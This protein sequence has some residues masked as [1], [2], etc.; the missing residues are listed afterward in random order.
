MTRIDRYRFLREY[1]RLNPIV[2]N[3]KAFLRG[4]IHE[5]RRRGLVYV[6]PHGVVMETLK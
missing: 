4:L 5:S 1:L 2:K 3:R 6:S